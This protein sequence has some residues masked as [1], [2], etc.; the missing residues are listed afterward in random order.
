VE[1][2]NKHRVERRNARYEKE[3]AERA[4]NTPTHNIH[5]NSKQS[6]TENGNQT[7]N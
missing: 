7:G 4:N 1:G 6:T 3:I 2:S 5:G